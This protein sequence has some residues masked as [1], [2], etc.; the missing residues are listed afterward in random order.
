[1][2]MKS[3]DLDSKRY[4]TILYFMVCEIL[5]FHHNTTKVPQKLK[6]KIQIICRALED[7]LTLSNVNSE[8]MSV[9][10]PFFIIYGD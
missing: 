2:S 1:M 7:V 5:Y 8:G 9:F 6:I 3:G 10:N 4:K